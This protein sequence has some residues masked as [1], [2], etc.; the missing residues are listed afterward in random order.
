MTLRERA[1]GRPPHSGEG[2]LMP[3]LRTKKAG[4]LISTGRTRVVTNTDPR[5]T[6][7]YVELTR[8]QAVEENMDMPDFGH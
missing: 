8:D 4:V 6:G 1:R 5:H 3:E 2:S 7:S